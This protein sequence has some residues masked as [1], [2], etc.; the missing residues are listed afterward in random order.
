MQDQ[1]KPKP[2]FVAEAVAPEGE[3]LLVP[4]TA[5]SALEA[6]S[7]AEEAARL[8]E[9]LRAGVTIRRNKPICSCGHPDCDIG[10]KEGDGTYWMD[11][12]TLERLPDDA[13]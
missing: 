1:L 6:K 5:A 12:D 3:K 10:P 7:A 8:A 11:A 4:N 9:S 13:R 2:V